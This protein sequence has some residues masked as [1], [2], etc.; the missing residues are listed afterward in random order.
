M[1][2]MNLRIN[3][4]LIRQYVVTS[5]LQFRGFFTMDWKISRATGL[6]EFK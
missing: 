2:A 3:F 6:A 1:G 4:K 5:D